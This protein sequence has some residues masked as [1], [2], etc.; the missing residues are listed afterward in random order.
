MNK[1]IFAG[2]IFSLMFGGLIFSSLYFREDG[3]V[4]SGAR[5]VYALVGDKVSK[6]GQIILELPE[7]L[8]KE[9]AEERISF[10]PPIEGSWQAADSPKHL[11]FKPKKSL[12]TG[13]YYSVQLST[14]EGL[15]KKDFQADEDPKVESV[16]PVRDA[17]ADEASAITMIFNR[18]MIPL[19]SLEETEE[20]NIPVEISPA[21]EG[22]FK[23][24]STRTLQFIPAKKLKGSS[25][26]RV[27]V[28]KGFISMDGLPVPPVDHSFKTRLLRFEGA[29]A[30]MIRYNQ[31]VSL[32]FNQPVDL[33]RTIQKMIVRDEA[34]GAAVPFVAEYDSYLTYD[35][36][37]KPK[38]KVVNRGIVNIYPASDRLGRAGLWNFN[39]SYSV[40]LDTAYPLD[41]EIKLEQEIRSN[42]SVTGMIEG[43][44]AISQKSDFASLELFDPEGKISVQ[45]YEEIDL[46]RSVIKSKGLTKT[47]YAQKCV[48]EE[49]FSFGKS[50]DDC[51]KTND[52][53]KIILSFNDSEFAKGE[54][55]ALMFEK[56]V[57]KSG[58]ILNETTDLR[59]VRVY[60]ELK[61]A[62]VQPDGISGASLTKMAICSNTPIREKGAEN[63]KEAIQADSRLVFS[64]WDGAYPQPRHDGWVEKYC[65]PGEFVS[66][67]RYGLLPQKEYNIKLL[68]EDHFGQKAGKNVSFQTG[69][70]ERFYRLFHNLQKVYNVTTPDKTKLTYAVENMEYVNLDICKVDPFTM[71]K[72][73][74]SRPEITASPDSLDCLERKT[75][76]IDLPDAYWVNNYF[77]VDIK[78]YFADPLGHYVLSFSHP[79]YRAEW[80]QKRQLHDKTLVSVTNLSV[81][82][83]QTRWTKYDQAENPELVKTAAGQKGNVVWVTK[84]KTL[85]GVGGA[86]V[87]VYKKEGR[88][89]IVLVSGR[90]TGQEGI[91]EFPLIGDIAGVVA[92]SG[93]DTAV[94]SAETDYLYYSSARAYKKVYIYSDRPIYRPGHEAHVKGL[95]RY[96]FDGNFEILNDKDIKVKV[97]NSKNESIFEAAVPPT[98]YGT[99]AAD[100]RIP[101]GA[102]LGTYRVEAMDSYYY[103]DVE[104]YVGAAFELGA[105]ADK[106]E[107]VSGDTINIDLLAKYYF[108]VPVDGG[109]VEY[110][111]T[112]QNYYF[113][114]YAD[115]YFNF[116]SD[117]YYCYRCGYGDS[118]IGSGTAELDQNG[119]AKIS[120]K[121]D[122]KELFRDRDLQSKIVT[123]YATVRDRQGKS[124][125]VQK[126]FIVHNG[127]FYLGVKAKESF[128]GEKEENLIKVKSVDIGGKPLAVKDITLEVNKKEW[129]SF[130]RQEVDG[131][132]YNKWEEVI[133]PVFK[134]QIKTDR[135]GDY[136][137]EFSLSES[138]QYELKVS[139]KDERG[140]E[141]SGKEELYVY[142]DSAVSVRPTNNESLEMETKTTEVKAGD[143]AKVIIKSPY[144]R[145][146]ALISIERGRIF[147][148]RVAEI[149]RNLFDFDF[150]VREEHIPNVFV[151]AVLISP[152]PEVRFGQLEFMVNRTRK[153]L[154]IDVR[155]N[156]DFY[157]PGEKVTLDIKAADSSGS[158]VSAEISVAVVD[159][160]VLAL[161]GNPKK[162]PVVFFYDGFPLAVSAAS[163]LKN[164][165]Q[166]MDIPSGTKGGGGG[167]P[168]DLATKKRGEFRDTAFWT[169]SMETDKFGHAQ[170]SFTLPDNLTRWQI[171]SLGI[172]QDTKLGVRYNEVEAKKKLM[173]TPIEPRFIIHGDEF[174]IGGKIFNETGET[175]KIAVELTSSSLELT[176]KTKETFSIK[177][178]E[179]ETVYFP[180]K[181]PEGKDSGRHD[182]TLSAKA[183]D[184]EDTVEKS[185]P[186]KRNETYEAVATANHTDEDAAQEYI[187]IPENVLTDKG[188]LIIKGNATLAVYLSD[189]LK[190][191]AEY[192]YGCSEQLASRISTL[193]I[194]K[195]GLLPQQGDLPEIDFEGK[196]YT[197]DE[198]VKLG[199]EKIYASQKV[200]GGFAYYPELEENFSLT[201]HILNTLSDAK[202]AGFKVR[203]G[204]LTN[205]AKYLADHMTG[206]GKEMAKDTRVDSLVNV[207][208]VFSRLETQPDKALEL[209]ME[210]T[211]LADVAY[212]SDKMSSGSL[213]YL[214]VLSAKNYPEEFK[215]R[216][217][218]SLINR[219]DIDSRGAYLKS[220]GKISL[221]FWETPVKN[222]ALMIKAIT[223]QKYEYGE[224]D[225]L[226]RWL[227]A[228]RS[229]DG[230]W[231]STNATLAVIDAFADY[232]AWKK[233]AEAD[234]ETT[235][236]L[237]G[238]FLDKFDFNKDTV[239]KTFEKF[240]P[241][242][243]FR[244]NV[245]EK[246]SFERMNRSDNKANFY[247]DMGLKYYLPIEQVAARDEGFSIERNFYALSDKEAANPLKTFKVGDVIRARLKITTPKE[248][249]LVAVEDFIPAGTE[250]INFN[251]ETE[252]MIMNDDRSD[253]DGGYGGAGGRAGRT[254]LGKAGGILSKMFGAAIA[255]KEEDF[256]GKV[257]YAEDIM[258][259]A[260]DLDFSPD[261]KELRDDRL[262]LFKESL[263]PGEY[264]YDYYLR[265]V[266]PGTFRHLPAVSGEMYFP[267]NFGR[268]KGDLFEVRL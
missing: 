151:S 65:Q 128:I 194:L 261:F 27:S 253:F 10:D 139:A 219:V 33:D 91:V 131:G 209:R 100:F 93:D 186:I 132:Y 200:S 59:T 239:F 182:F 13:K 192:P 198:A 105:D 19:T 259:S 247:Y 126:S 36:N 231:G 227:L 185:I 74:D 142:G 94:V 14:D 147:E 157:L 135:N 191:M 115:E 46:D 86:E 216:I 68:L 255:V 205:G 97:Y 148:Y 78:K 189:A 246:I 107:Y 169:G 81:A 140:N 215:R 7:G 83:K 258:R 144:P 39:G 55:F 210:L 41:G 237:N 45:F 44:E 66:V 163:N 138:G 9:G 69:Q 58:Q 92:A 79:D 160:S 232:L 170:I 230:A 42:V 196:K 57:N 178:G 16:F 133:T 114:K 165:L 51:E 123:F 224:T 208:Y 176:G 199:L 204:S 183:K 110:G 181:A 173:L 75:D 80:G 229:K 251:L 71:L 174:Y 220:G 207:L 254:A 87:K 162:D 245:A 268:A 222:T 88:D 223:A 235:L 212:I 187:Y 150:D 127:E 11:A 154:S 2:I 130:R 143:K 52:F 195:K 99:F 260:A 24:V 109:T 56:I 8:P 242:S 238:Q 265:A 84:M 25:E 201:V 264:V 104:E 213:A 228:G 125:S 26:Y 31:P 206:K 184:Y 175:Q 62:K 5:Q 141:I 6:S 136:E 226:M 63:Y 124:V 158:P 266:V 137:E 113:D 166:Q 116:G 53:T 262:F 134:K 20:Q 218:K 40:F 214:G 263:S 70:P 108:G 250:L 221:D 111:F 85:E 120:Q 48:E 122:L 152:D 18:P 89:S 243:S 118:H 248:R 252:K 267:E 54:E 22:K 37:N 179:T 145:A 35:K 64:R 50:G 106:E 3:R 60:P 1:K 34:S 236:K 95:Y 190:Y 77:Q 233:E 21:T 12:E 72:Y 164:V 155:P 102:P 28:K 129:K 96:N 73:A 101:D 15:I 256:K 30:G 188:G 217:M 4:I 249:S 38:E 117:W 161:K 180:V 240:L 146:K 82:H 159:L 177:N 234:Y 244:T 156:K 112:S 29:T 103:F 49:E 67:I 23:W 241:V 76:T 202:E 153:E 17:E 119:K 193:A 43:I 211:R 203:E 98:K 168:A 167:G 257:V 171:E 225:R 32:N 47:E 172:T 121:I 90:L 149:N 197:I 61:I